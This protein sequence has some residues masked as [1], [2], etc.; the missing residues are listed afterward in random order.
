MSQILCSSPS[1][2]SFLSMFSLSLSFYFTLSL[3][4]SFYFT[5]S[6][7]L[8]LL[9]PLSLFPSTSPSLSLS[10]Y[11]TLSLSLLL[12]HPLSLSPS[13]SPS[14]SPSTSPSLSLSFYFIPLSVS[15]FLSF[16]PF[17][18]FC[19]SFL[20][21]PSFPQPSL[22]LFMPPYSSLLS[23]LQF[24]PWFLQKHFFNILFFF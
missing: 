21:A 10:F 4:L 3:S 5:L 18:S 20:G 13:T 11:F 24:S 2:S 6:L 23:F 8:L 12:L 17:K 7:S 9:H 14:L 16:L 19:F 15:F 1:L 22:F